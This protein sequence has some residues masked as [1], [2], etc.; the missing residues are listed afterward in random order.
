MPSFAAVRDI[1]LKHLPRPAAGS[2]VSVGED[3]VRIADPGV[4]IGDLAHFLDDL[5]GSPGFLPPGLPAADIRLSKL[6]LTSRPGGDADLAFTVLWD[7]ASLAVAGAFPLRLAKVDFALRG[8]RLKAFAEARL[9][10]DDYALDVSF[11]LPA[12][13]VEVRVDPDAPPAGTM[14]LLA[15]RGLVA[16]GSA[17][18]L[19]ALAVSGSLLFERLLLYVELENLFTIGPVTLASATADVLLAGDGASSAA[20]GAEILIAAPNHP[21]LV[22]DVEGEVDAQGWRVAGSLGIAGGFNIGDLAAS[23]AKHFNH[24]APQLPDVISK[25]ALERL[26]VSLDTH[27]ESFTVDCTLDWPHSAQVLVHFARSGGQFLVT[28]SL[29]LGEVVFKVAFESGEAVLVGSYEAAGGKRLTLDEVLSALSVDTAALFGKGGSGVSLDVRAVAVALDGHARVLMGA[30]VDAGI[31]LSRLGD[32]PLV[33]SLLPK[34]EPL[35]LRISPY[36]MGDQFAAAQ[37][38]RK[39]MPASLEL[40]DTLDSG[41]HLA[42]SLHLGGDP[43]KLDAVSLGSDPAKAASPDTGKPSAVS[44]PAPAGT[45]MTWKDVRKALGPLKI[46]RVGYATHNKVLDLAIDAA[47]EVAG[48]TVSVDGLGARYDFDTRALSTHLRGL[49]LDFRRGP[50]EIAGAFLNAD[51]DFLGRMVISGKQFSLH[52]L[53]AFMMLDGAPSMFA[54]GVLDMPLGGPV[55]FFVEGLAAGF[56]LHRRIHMPPIDAVRSFPLVAGAGIKSTNKVD[57]RSEL[58]K[59]HDYVLPQFGEYFF[60][61]G[62]KFNSFRLLHGFAVLV[63]SVG[64]DLEIDLI[65]TADFA[66]PPDL[67]ENVPA[68][69]RIELD[70]LARF[71]PGEGLLAVEARLNPE[72]YVYGPLCHLSG[73]FAFYAWTADAHKGD[74]VLSVGGYHPEYDLSAHPHYPSVPRV[75]LKYQVSPEVYLKGD[76]YFALTPSIMMAGGGLHANATVGALHAWADFSVDFWVAWEPFHYDATVHVGIGAQLGCFHTSASADLH[77]WGPAFSGTAHVQWTIFSFDVEFGPHTPVVPLPITID[78]FKKS[79]LGID[80]SPGSANAIL[81]VVAAEGVLGDAQGVPVVAP[82]QLVLRTSSRVPAMAVK[83]GDVDQKIKAPAL[84]ITPAWVTALRTSL[85]SIAIERETVDVAGNRSVK[86]VSEAFSATPLE[87]GFPAALWG[88]R[89]VPDEDARPIL[90]VSEVRLSPKTP[91]QPARSTARRVDQLQYEVTRISL[92]ESFMSVRTIGPLPTTLPAADLKALGLDAAALVY[93]A[94]DPS[95]ARI[96]LGAQPTGGA[97]A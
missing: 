52:A 96:E 19:R 49:G 36:F 46:G 9:L 20:A 50:L 91:T 47:L 75:E 86:D 80:G 11:E 40:P 31:D 28:G 74:F 22:I 61:A 92:R 35:G 93:V 13:V 44:A 95:R 63:V 53:G 34:G 65:G 67:P 76:A 32:L 14:D 51:G 2:P 90:A 64:R 85:H 83:L 39:R 17:A 41:V 3:G 72:S 89:T 7:N 4:S 59:L 71:A 48:L 15:S 5:S 12:Q 77:I 1:L 78:K 69:A 73:G 8:H 30:E 43:I 23:F 88:P 33:G 55:F 57:P 16:K 62:I 79:F 27:D 94:P 82:A 26:A 81:G 58:Q 87:T 70:L 37:A 84:G 45:A 42:A 21:D 60:A 38:A 6:D 54:Y 66:S 68:L 10:I 56:G 25:L 24:P 18:R 97:V 29:V